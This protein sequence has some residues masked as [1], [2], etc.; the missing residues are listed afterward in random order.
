MPEPLSG[1]RIVV[2][3]P[4]D[5][6]QA[7]AARLE[8]AGATTILFPTIRIA[9]PRD[10]APLD[11]SLARLPSYDRV[12]FTSVNG[13]RHVA[14]RLQAL[15]L[16]FPDDLPVAAIGP[17]TAAALRRLGLTPDLVPEDYVAEAIAEGL[18]DVNGRA[19]LL[20]RA[21]IAREALARLL[22]ERGARV[23]EVVAYHTLP[24]RPEPGARHALEAGVDVLTFTSSSTVRNFVA[25]LGEQALRIASG[26]V[27]ACIG[28][29][30]AGTARN[31]GL[32]PD[33]IARTYTTEGLLEALIDHFAD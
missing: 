21:D 2:T 28:P 17:A 4:R 1:L 13:V 19:I 27:V 26:A 7:F 29:I 15:G 31:L 23:D 5:Q 11:A 8:A 24:D 33:V 25:L 10:T 3:R 20:P 9:P 16:T 14:R 12:I 32:T 6:A 18:G 22:R 30:T